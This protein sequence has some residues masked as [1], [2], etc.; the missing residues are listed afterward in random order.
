LF[1]Q[2]RTNGNILEVRIDRAQPARGRYRQ[3]KGRVHAAFLVNQL[4][5]G[6]NV[7][8]LKLRIFTILLYAFNNGVHP[9]QLLQHVRGSTVVS[10]FAFFADF[11][12]QVK[13]NEKNVAQLRRTAYVELLV[14]VTIDGLF[15]I[16]D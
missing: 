11:P 1:A 12:W 16:A 8:A 7:S 4:W 13:L 5:Q 3:I 6:V 9:F 15:N 14:G 10:G 2:V